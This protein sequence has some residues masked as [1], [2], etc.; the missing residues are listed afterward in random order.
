MQS[1]PELRAVAQQVVRIN[2]I[3]KIAI[4]RDQVCLSKSYHCSVDLFSAVGVTSTAYRESFYGPFQTVH[5]RRSLRSLVSLTHCD[6]RSDPNAFQKF[7]SLRV[8]F[9]EAIDHS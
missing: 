9:T 5:H 6:L 3:D 2:A 4:I 8:V 7:R 1:R